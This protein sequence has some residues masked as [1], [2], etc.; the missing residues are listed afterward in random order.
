[1]NA[2][3]MADTFGVSERTAR[4]RSA[5][6]AKTYPGSHDYSYRRGSRSGRRPYSAL[7][8]DLEMAR[9]AVRRLA[10]AATSF[11]PDDD[12]A[13]LRTI[14]TEADALLQEEWTIAVEA[15]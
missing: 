6:T 2:K 13:E 7:A 10:R 4:R 14:A 11:S 8:R 9:N 1:M 3:E 15:E 12:L 5:T